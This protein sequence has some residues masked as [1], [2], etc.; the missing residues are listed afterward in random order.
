MVFHKLFSNKG[1]TIIEVMFSTA[2]AS[3]VIVLAMAAMNRGVATTQMAVEHTLVRQ[4]IDSQ[5]EALRYLRDNKGASG[6]TS[7]TAAWNKVIAHPRTSAT[8]FSGPCATPPSDAFYIDTT[9]TGAGMIKP[10]SGAGGASSEVFAIPGRGIWIEAV[11]P[12]GA[13]NYVDFHIRACWEPPF[14]GPDA[15]LGT[16]V[17]LTK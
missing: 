6:A 13:A 11:S 16:I 7:T 15:T 8:P 3:L 2:V 14:S 1:D 17:R 12:L 10:A 4:G 5:T 9:T